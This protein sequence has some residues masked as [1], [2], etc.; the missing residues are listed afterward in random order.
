MNVN[1]SMK[2]LDGGLPNVCNN[3]LVMRNSQYLTLYSSL[4][5]SKFTDHSWFNCLFRIAYKTSSLTLLAIVRE[6][7][8]D[9]QWISATKRFYDMTSSWMAF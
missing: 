5:V 6:I 3:I 7:S 1:I 9:D 4:M 8:I 2:N